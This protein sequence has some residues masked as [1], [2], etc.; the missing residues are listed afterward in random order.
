MRDIEERGMIAAAMGWIGTLGTISAYLMLSR[1]RWSSA[2]FRYSAINGVGGLLCA[3]GAAAYGA[4]PSAFA[5]LLW[6]VVAAHT[7][8]MTVLERR[9]VPMAEVVELPVGPVDPEP[10]TG[11]QPVLLAA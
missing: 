10:P 1:G 9:T 11:P 6:S 7:M 2:S 5:N 8:V 3:A 4:W